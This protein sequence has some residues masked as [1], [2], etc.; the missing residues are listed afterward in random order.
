MNPVS[1]LHDASRPDDDV[2]ADPLARDGLAVQTRGLGK[3]FGS[4]AALHNVDLDV[5]R[6][7]AFGFLGPNG[8]GKTTL[9]RLLLGLA[10]PTSGRIRLLGHDLPEG[11]AVA[12]GHG[13]VALGSSGFTRTQRSG[14]LLYMR[15]ADR[16]R[17]AASTGA[18][19]RVGSPRGLTA[20]QGSAGIDRPGIGAAASRPG[21]AI[22]DE[23]MNGL[24]RPESGLRE[25]SG[26]R[27]GGARCC[28][29]ASVDEVEDVRRAAIVDGARSSL[30]HDRE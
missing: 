5:P 23:P 30:R 26:A 14:N 9:I 12:L 8:T 21:A 17:T 24:D 20:R 1:E 18:L 2:S 28:C 3:R 4:R 19:A 29:P 15:G 16:S 10:K 22:L 13:R 6:G 7:C 11:A 25:D 27:R